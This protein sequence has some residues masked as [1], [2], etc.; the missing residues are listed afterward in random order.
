MGV[1]ERHHNSQLPLRAGRTRAVRRVNEDARSSSSKRDAWEACSG[2]LLFA[3]LRHPCARTAAN[4]LL[5][6]AGHLLM[7]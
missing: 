1:R 7:D 6:G 3:V 4:A 2:Q 5:S